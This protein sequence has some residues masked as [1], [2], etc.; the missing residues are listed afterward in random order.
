MTKTFFFLSLALIFAHFPAAYGVEEPE[1]I[2]VTALRSES[3]K[4]SFPAAVTVITADQTERGG[5]SGRR[6]ERSRWS[7]GQ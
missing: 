1:T 3:V 2:V 6:I 5:T 4:D 7:G